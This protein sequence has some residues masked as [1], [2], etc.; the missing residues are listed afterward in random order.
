MQQVIISAHGQLLQ[1]LLPPPEAFVIPGVRW[2]R[3]DHALTPAFWRMTAWMTD[4]PSPRSYQLGA[5]LGEELAACLLGGYGIPA[6]VG[7]AAFKRVQR[8]LRDTAHGGLPSA[9]QLEGLL[10][11]PLS[12]GGRQVRYRFARQKA[13]QLAEAL[14]VVEDIHEHE[15]ADVALRDRLTELPGVGL[16]TASWIVRNRRSSAQV[17]IL[18][19]HL[20]RACQLM[21]VFEA[22]DDPARHYHSMEKRFLAFCS[23]LDESAALMDAVMWATMRQIPPP[24]MKLILDPSVATRHNAETARRYS[25]LEVAGAGMT[26]TEWAGVRQPIHA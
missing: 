20:V 16:K 13:T 18:D 8:A 15:L 23:G 24:L 25:C 7:L 19:V 10:A 2:G 4:D 5:S 9:A 11:A 14:R 21:G 22:S 3:F 17:A 12:V 1:R 6:E 26:A